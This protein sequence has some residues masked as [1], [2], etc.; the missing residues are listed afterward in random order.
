MRRNVRTPTARDLMRLGIWAVW[1][2]EPEDVS[3]LHVLF[4]IRSAGSFE[5]LIDT[6]GGAQDA[7]VVG[8]TQLISLRMAEE[9]G[10]RVRLEAPVRRIEHGEGGV[11]VARRRHRGR[12]PPGDRRDPAG[13]RRPDRLRPAAAGASATGSPSGW[14]RGASS[15]AWPSTRSRSG[16]TRASP[17]QAT[18]ADGPVSVTYDNSPPD[19][20]PGV[21]L[22]FLE[23]RAARQAARCREAERR[24]SVLGCLRRFFGAA[25]RRPRALRRPRL[26]ERALDPAAATAASC[27]PA[28]GSRTG[29][30]LRRADRPD[31]LGRRRDGDRLE[32]LHGRRDQLRRARGR[33]GAGGDA[34]ADL[35]RATAVAAMRLK[36]LLKN[37]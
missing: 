13:A 29:R 8:G 24:A 30:A 36:L 28:P 23:G 26:A 7:R 34:M 5:E 10:D 4:Y 33:G 17:G 16:A 2:A 35:D 6:E 19:G 31:P 14:R 20:S 37:Y 11:T 25:G 1:A 22:G 32:R 3:L 21:L 18:S 9:L 15:S 27:R 12:G